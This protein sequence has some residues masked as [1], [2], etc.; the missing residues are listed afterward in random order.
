M[1]IDEARQIVY[2]AI[3]AGS[4]A[5]HWFQPT[6]D[7]EAGRAEAWRILEWAG[8]NIWSRE[9]DRMVFGRDVFGWLS[10]TD[11]ESWYPA[12]SPAESLLRAVAAAIQARKESQP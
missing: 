5:P 11:D 8:K 12:D 10:L 3:H 1:T 7:T 6:A 4:P 2:E 9:T